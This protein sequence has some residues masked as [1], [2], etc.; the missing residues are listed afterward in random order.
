MFISQTRLPH[1]LAPAAYFSAEQYLREQ[2]AVLEPGWH[3]VATTNELQRDGDFITRELFGHPVQLRNFDGQLRALSNVC[4]HRHCLLTGKRKGHSNK[5]K[6]QYHGW[7][8][9]PD[10][11]TRKIPQPKN[12]APFPEDGERIPIYRVA[13]CGQIV[14][15]CLSETAPGLQD[16]L[17]D[18]YSI[19]EE[20]FGLQTR[21]CLRMDVDYAAN[22]KVPIENTL[23]AYHVPN[24]HEHTFRE[25][26]GEERST[27]L[28]EDR[29]TAFGTSLPFSP[30]SRIDAFFQRSEFA[31]VKML[32][33]TPRNEY[34]QHH[35]YPNLLLSFTD[36]ISLMHCII[37][38]GPTT[39]TAIVRQFGTMGNSRWGPRRWMAVLWGQ[40]KGTITKK[41]MTEDLNLIPDIQAGLEKSEQRGVLGRCEERIHAFQAFI[42]AKTKERTIGSE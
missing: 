37:P 38:T 35:L 28:L 7:E 5:M 30:H 6:C 16:F 42:S 26:P 21:E 27:H 19:I 29:T 23:E 20:R 39:A 24:V 22:W 14:F 31:I 1:L 10:G 4:A 18:Y 36:A 3:A 40:L 17:G 32:G 2:A 41:I 34:W 11:K 13:T 9:G 25:D 8:Y 33:V 12:F 15:V